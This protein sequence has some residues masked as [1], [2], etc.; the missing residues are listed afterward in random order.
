MANGP[1]SA[2]PKD[3]AIPHSQHKQEPVIPATEPAGTSSRTEPVSPIPVLL[4]GQERA[5]S[6]SV[7]DRNGPLHLLD[8]PED[9][10]RLIVQEA[11]PASIS[12]SPC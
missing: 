4:K 12:L 11:S 9:L 10:L 8:L 3:A 7:K 2:F 5:Q 1:G 6:Y